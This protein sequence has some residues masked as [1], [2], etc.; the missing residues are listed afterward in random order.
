MKNFVRLVFPA[1]FLSAAAWSSPLAGAQ[2]DEPWH[3]EWIVVLEDTRSDRRRGWASGVGYSGSYNYAEDPKLARLTRAIASDYGLEVTKQWPIR[4]LKVHCV[5]VRLTADRADVLDALREDRRIRWVQR[6]QD[7]EAL[8][9]ADPYRH[10]QSSLTTMNVAPLHARYAGAGV[11]IALIDSGVEAD[12]PDLEHALAA[13]VDFVGGGQ[14]A[15]R[16]GTGIAGVLVAGASNGEGIS[17]VAPAAELYAYRACW[18]KDSGE[19]RCNSLTLSLALDHALVIQPQI[20]NLS[21]TGPEDRL[22]DAL[23]RLLVDNGAIVVAAHDPARSTN[24]FPSPGRGVLIVHDGTGVASPRGSAV[25]AP[26]DAVL[27]AQPGHSYDFMGGSS[28]SAAHVSGV[29][30][31]LLEATPG[32]SAA[33]SE[34]LLA[35]SVRSVDTVASIDACRAMGCGNLRGACEDCVSADGKRQ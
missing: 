28:L 3:E 7:F 33:E 18:E 31:L 9:R 23:V 20:V 30:A 32:L 19:T 6:L 15:E 21:L 2:P 12:H 11:R 4:A 16:H 5:V 34:E 27:T 10:L 24:R 14:V 17:G 8:G 25:Y 29:L 13:N 26:G 35:E 1:V 22:L